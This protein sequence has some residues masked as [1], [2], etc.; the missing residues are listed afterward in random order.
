MLLHMVRT[1]FILQIFF[2]TRSNFYHTDIS[3][4]YANPLNDSG[5]LGGAPWRPLA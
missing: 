3:V 1:S 2:D 5:M 4:R